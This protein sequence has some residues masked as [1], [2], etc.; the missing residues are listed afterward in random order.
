[1]IVSLI[2]GCFYGILFGYLD[3]E[4][5]IFKNHS[6]LRQEYFCFPIGILMG[7]IGG[8]LNEYFRLTV[9]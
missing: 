1:M 3:L 5:N 9:N 7:G 4:D 6:F 2:M 8:G